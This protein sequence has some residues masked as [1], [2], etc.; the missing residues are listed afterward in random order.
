MAATPFVAIS[1]F[2][3]Q[4]ASLEIAA[5]ATVTWENQDA[6]PHT[7]TAVDG[8]FDSGQLLSGAS[9]DATFE[10]PGTFDYACAIHPSMTGTIVVS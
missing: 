6:A 7:V 3:F 4:P 10:Q 9:F 1:G 2:S 8:S 5:G